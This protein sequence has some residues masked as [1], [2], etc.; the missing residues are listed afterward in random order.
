MLH[1]SE[2]D[3]QEFETAM[4]LYSIAAVVMLSLH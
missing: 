3:E 2:S 1:S 4:Q